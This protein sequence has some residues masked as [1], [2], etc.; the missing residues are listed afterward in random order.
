MFIFYLLGVGLPCSLIFCQFWLCEEAQCV[1]LRPHLG[2]LLILQLS[3][4]VL[5]YLVTVKVM[6]IALK[7]KT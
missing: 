6:T 4:P 1:Y 5:Y 7:Q 3:F 2:S